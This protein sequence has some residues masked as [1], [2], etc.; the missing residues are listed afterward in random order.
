MKKENY[1][2]ADGTHDVERERLS[3]L[4]DAY[5]PDTI[6]QLTTLGVSGGWKCLEVGA[7]VG[8]IA[9]WLAETV[10]SSGKVVATDMNIRFLRELS[11]PQ[12]EVREHN[13]LIDTLETESFDIVHSRGV[14]MHL[15]DS[16]KA[17]RAMADAVRPGGWLFIEDSDLSPLLTA[18]LTNPALDAV[19]AMFR[20]GQMFWKAQGAMDPYFG[21][22]E[23]RLVQE[24]GFNE[25]GGC[26]RVQT[27]QGGEPLARVYQIICQYMKEVGLSQGLFTIEDYD[28]FQRQLSDPSITWIDQVVYG[29][30]GRKPSSRR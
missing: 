6:R 3:I 30:W 14:L 29:A 1:F 10:G 13:I 24:L 27:F 4:E 7:G 8:S 15:S 19:V 17:L 12:L 9:R 22:Y 20:R 25:V 28:T 5:D 23:K 2:A 11:L 16:R 18:N 21:R 26:G